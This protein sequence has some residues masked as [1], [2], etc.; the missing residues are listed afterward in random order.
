MNQSEMIHHTDEH[1]EYLH[2][3]MITLF[4]TSLVL[5]NTMINIFILLGQASILTLQLGLINACM[6][7]IN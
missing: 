2:E 6:R 7:I 3:T 1:Q 5:S 4:K